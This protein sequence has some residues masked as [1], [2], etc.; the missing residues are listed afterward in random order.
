MGLNI[1]FCVVVMMT[2]RIAHVGMGCLDR[3]CLHRLLG[4]W[5]PVFIDISLRSCG[6]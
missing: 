4:V 6:E 1:L 5:S 2:D 3:L